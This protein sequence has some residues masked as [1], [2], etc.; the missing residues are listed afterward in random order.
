MQ[1]HHEDA[2][3]VQEAE[4]SMLRRVG[5]SEDNILITQGNLAMHV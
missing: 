5:A 4:L 2:L 3:S 1:D